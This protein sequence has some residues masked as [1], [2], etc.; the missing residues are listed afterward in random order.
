MA[1]E[2]PVFATLSPQDA[3]LLRETLSR[4]APQ[5]IQPLEDGVPDQALRMEVVDALIGEFT[6]SMLPCT[7]WEPS[8][9]GLAVEELIGNFLLKYPSS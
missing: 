3:A 9:H 8:V 5:L 2:Q 4:V 7:D 6:G 1:D